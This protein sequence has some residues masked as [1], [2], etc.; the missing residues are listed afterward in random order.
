MGSQIDKVTEGRQI[1][2]TDKFLHLEQKANLQHHSGVVAGDSGGDIT[3]SDRWCLLGLF[4]WTINQS[5]GELHTVVVLLLSPRASMDSRS[6][7]LFAWVSRFVFACSL[8]CFT[9]AIREKLEAHI[10]EPAPFPFAL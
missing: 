9:H 8:S 1:W 3:G 6:L 2:K 5:L 7:I 4:C 10:D